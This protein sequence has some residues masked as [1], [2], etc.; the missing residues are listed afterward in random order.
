M[1]DRMFTDC[2]QFQILDTVVQAVVVDVMH[3]LIPLQ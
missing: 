1:T 3:V 2:D